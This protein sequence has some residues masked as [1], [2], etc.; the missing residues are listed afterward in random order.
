MDCS[1][2]YPPSVLDP[3]DLSGMLTKSF[4]SNAIEA[5]Q[6]FLLQV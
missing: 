2:I 1:N 6:N 4:P 5:H 3:P